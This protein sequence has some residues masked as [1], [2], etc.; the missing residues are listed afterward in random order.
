MW[1]TIFLFLLQSQQPLPPLKQHLTQSQR[2]CNLAYTWIERRNKGTVWDA[3]LKS[4]SPSKSETETESPL[5]QSCAGQK[6][7]L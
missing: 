4:H 6:T 1:V 3:E 7:P 5:T 2:V